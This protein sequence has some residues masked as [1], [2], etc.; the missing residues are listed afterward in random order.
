MRQLRSLRDLA[1]LAITGGLGVVLILAGV[2]VLSVGSLWSYL[3]TFPGTLF[4][5]LVG[6]CL[7]LV[8]IDFLVR[9]TDERLNAVLFSQQGDWGQIEVSPTAVREFIS[10][11]LRHQVGIDRF[12]IFLRHHSGGVAI[13][14]RTALSPDQRVTDVGTRIQEE[15]ARHV[16]ERT[17]IDVREVTVFVRSLRA[18]ADRPTEQEAANDADD[19]ER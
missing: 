1:A 5:I 10:D 15:L 18:R 3:E 12:R 11:I 17:G 7:L 16:P 6:A 4:V 13:S 8:A 9:L 19:V 2:G 14:V